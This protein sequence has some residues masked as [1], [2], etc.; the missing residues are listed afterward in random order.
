MQAAIATW[1]E[2]HLIPEMVKL[3]KLPIENATDDD[4]IKIRSVHASS[5]EISGFALTAPFKVHV[6]LYTFAN[7]SH[8]TAHNLVVKKTPPVPPEMYAGAQFDLL[9]KNEAVAYTEIIPI[10]SDKEKYPKYYY[11]ETKATEATLVMDDFSNNG[12]KMSKNVYDLSLDYILC[13]VFEIGKFHGECYA[14]KESKPEVF[15]NITKKLSETRYNNMDPTYQIVMKASVGRAIKAVQEGEYKGKIPAEFLLQLGLL[16]SNDPKKFGF[17]AVQPVE[18]L[19]IITHSDFLRNNIAFKYENDDPDSKPIDAMMFDMQTMR[20]SS[21][22][23]DLVTLLSNSAMHD[24]RGANLDL[25]LK[26]YH[27][28]LTNTLQAKMKPNYKIP[29][30]Y[31]FDNFY[32][33]YVRMVPYGLHISTTFLPMLLEPIDNLHELMSEQFDPAKMQEMLTNRGGE[34]VNV[35]IAHQIHEC[36]ELYSKLNMNLIDG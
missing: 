34:T 25:I 12:W 27:D 4:E 2:D 21:P 9:F 7:P 23:I 11:S 33:E 28:T 20:Y 17:D 1:I 10:L 29:E 31:N 6:E 18:P 24:V 30:K 3:R 32:K 26:K 36:Y 19:A 8:V 13:A 15:Y 35:E 22:A 14:L 16:L 5:L